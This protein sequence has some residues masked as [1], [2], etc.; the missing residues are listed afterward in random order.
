MIRVI[1]SCSI[2]ASVDIV[3]ESLSDNLYYVN[4]GV[5]MGWGRIEQGQDRSRSRNHQENDA[6][7]LMPGPGGESVADAESSP[8]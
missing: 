5:R 3:E 2:R 4:Y 7:P 8:V 6:V 1:N